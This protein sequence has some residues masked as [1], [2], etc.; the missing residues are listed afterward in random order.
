MG[1]EHGNYLNTATPNGASGSA[2]VAKGC[3]SN[4]NLHT[5]AVYK[6][7]L[8]RRIISDRLCYNLR[9]RFWIAEGKAV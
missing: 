3:K 4:R 9:C 8:T 7:E 5:Q 6:I 2:T 1:P